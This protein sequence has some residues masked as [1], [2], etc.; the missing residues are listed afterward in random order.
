MWSWCW[1]LWSRGWFFSLSSSS[2]K[3]LLLLRLQKKH[4]QDH[5]NQHQ[6]H[7]HHHQDL[8]PTKITTP[9]LLFRYYSNYV[10]IPRYTFIYRKNGYRAPRQIRSFGAIGRSSASDRAQTAN[11]GPKAGYLGPKA[12]QDRPL[13]P[14]KQPQTANLGPKSS[15][16]PPT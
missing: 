4:P 16:R 13:R 9:P 7:K 14:R 12:S 2:G 1:F 15:H 5:G 8:P 6:D 10:Y 11:I 3:P